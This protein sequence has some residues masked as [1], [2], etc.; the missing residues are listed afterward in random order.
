MRLQ[1]AAQI[2]VMIVHD[3]ICFAINV[4]QVGNTTIMLLLLLLLVLIT[5]RAIIQTRITT[6]ISILTTIG[7]TTSTTTIDHEIAIQLVDR[8]TS[9]VLLFTFQ[10]IVA[11]LQVTVGGQIYKITVFTSGDRVAH[12]LL[13]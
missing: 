6:N 2:V 11:A 12:R 4:H 9:L 10:A 5:R 7:H 1:Q 3:E 8:F 13:D